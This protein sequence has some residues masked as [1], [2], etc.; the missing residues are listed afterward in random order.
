MIY[1]F[2][3]SIPPPFI[4]IE[5]FFFVVFLRNMLLVIAIVRV[6]SRQPAQSEET[7]ISG[8]SRATPFPRSSRIELSQ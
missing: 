2:F 6:C 1:P 8:V 3:S 5:G 4:R 7:Q